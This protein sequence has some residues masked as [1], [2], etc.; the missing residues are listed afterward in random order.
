MNLYYLKKS[1]QV[2]TS[3]TKRLTT[4]ADA[5]NLA[6]IRDFAIKSGQKFGFNARQLNGLKLS[7]DEICTNIIRYAYNDMKKG[8][9]RIEMAR[10]NNDVVTRII[11]RGVGFD[12]SEVTDPDIDRYVK[13]RKKGGFGIYLVR[14]LND[15]VDYKRAG[16]RN[17]LTLTNKVEPRPAI[18]ELIRRNFQPGKMTIR[19]KFAVV[20]T[21][22]ITCISV[23]TYF[24]MSLAQKRELIRQY[25]DNYITVL[26]NFA[27]TTTE[28]ILSERVLLLEE[29]IYELIEEEPS[30]VRLAVIDRNS[31]IIADKV[32]Q[33]IG[34]HHSLP[35]GVVPLID[36]EYLVQ[37]YSDTEYGPAYY[38]TVP[39]RIADA[40][41]GKAFL[42]IQKERMTEVVESRVNRMRI[43]LYILLFWFVG[44]VGI[45]FMGNMFVTPVKRIT[46][47][48]NRVGKEGISGGFHFSGY[49]EFA[50][51][52]TAFNKMMREIK[53]SEVE[54]TDQARLKKEMQLAQSIQQTLLPRKVPETEGF[55]ISAKYDAAM[56]VGGDYYDFF[57]VDDNSIGITVGDVSGK[58]I[59][60]AFIMSIVR[61]ALR[62]EARRQKDAS[63]VLVRLNTTL[64]G[65]FKKGMYI[66]LFY[67]ILDSKRRVIN[68][69]SA[70][71]TPMI[72]Y[73]A[74][75][76]QI[77]RL[78]PRGFP[79]GLNVGDLKL[80]RKSMDNERIS[81]KKG[82]LLLVYTDGITEAMN[83]KRQ[84]Y[85]EERLLE[86]IRNYKHLSTAEF[87]DQMIMDIRDFT[88]G[89][90]Q[91]DDITFIVIR[92]K[93][94]YDEL[95]YQKR[96]MLFDL[97]EKEG[98]TIEKACREVGISKSSYYRLKKAR[99]E[100]GLKAFVSQTERGEINVADMDISQKI[101]SVVMKNPEYSAR[102][103][104]EV[105]AKE[106][107]SDLDIDTTLIYRELKRLKLSTKEKRVAY[108][109]RKAAQGQST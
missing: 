105:L 15:S 50:D 52:S 67:I 5:K 78:N 4:P 92:D 39:I 51:I 77:Y 27:A 32:V 106:E 80:F 18:W 74:E 54:L 30:I 8:D 75:T 57:Y 107:G 6:R 47:E 9:I 94:M 38:Y 65:E 2:K 49:G 59:G 91:S 61:T 13:E 56:E 29:Q 76:D 70:G 23:G 40:Y 95:Q 86:T 44:I 64:Q 108:V 37:E 12:Y 36:Q 93:E 99:D 100:Q 103:I 84:E 33:N 62:L 24:L 14:Q 104:G 26:K 42:A 79:I 20:A 45:S 87:A 63:Q 85:G 102:K 48:L 7:L 83:K 46:E 34:K 31:T 69:A 10:T 19:V 90:P 89:T 41:V 55:E 101:L 88:G 72:L 82:D 53:K 22:V 96:T 35:D 3:R 66:T 17:I 81:L 28:Y 25:I 60:G 71:H 43:L 16:N 11:D 1:F 58:G 98:Y 109:R 68:Y 97:I 73:R 21:L